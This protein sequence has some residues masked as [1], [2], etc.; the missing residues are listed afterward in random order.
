[1]FYTRPQLLQIPFPYRKMPPLLLATLLFGWIPF[2]FDSL[3][4][5]LLHFLSGIVFQRHVQ[6]G[7]SGNNEGKAD[8]DAEE[9]LDEVGILR[10]HTGFS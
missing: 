3:I 5:H 6:S 8:G 10:I 2:R 7:D 1:M 9:I 4:L